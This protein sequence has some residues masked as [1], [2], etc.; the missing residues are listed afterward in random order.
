[1]A[2]TRIWGAKTPKP[3]ATKLCMLDAVQDL[4]KRA[5]FGKDPL[6]G[7]VW[8]WVEFWHFPFTCFVAFKMLSHY[9]A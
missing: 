9:R 8:R 6:R 5:N 2:K 7:L 4:I 3:I 1:M